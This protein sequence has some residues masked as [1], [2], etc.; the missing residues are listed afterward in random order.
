MTLLHQDRVLSLKGMRSDDEILAF[1]DQ[2]VSKLQ[3]V[4]LRSDWEKKPTTIRGAR[5]RQWHVR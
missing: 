5:S 2:Q 1:V 3:G 4:Q